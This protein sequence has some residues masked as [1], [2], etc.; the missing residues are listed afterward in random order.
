M[1]P[2]VWLKGG[3]GRGGGTCGRGS[4]W[5]YL[6]LLLHIYTLPVTDKTSHFQDHV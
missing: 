2:V 5:I 4:V 3:G 1:C 6:L